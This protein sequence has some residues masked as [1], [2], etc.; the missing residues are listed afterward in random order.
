MKAEKVRVILLETW[1]P[2]DV[3]K[4]VARE[5]GAK[6][7][8]VPQTPGAVQ[9]TEDYIAHLDYLVTTVVNALH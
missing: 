1:Y 8:V 3:A 9:G 7:L 6:V 2:A 4:L 5:S